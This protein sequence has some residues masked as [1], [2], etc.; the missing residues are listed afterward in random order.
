MNSKANPATILDL[1]AAGVSVPEEDIRLLEAFYLRDPVRE[2]ELIAAGWRLDLDSP[3]GSIGF[4]RTLGGQSTPFVRYDM[5]VRQEGVQWVP[6]HGD[7]EMA[8]APSAALAAQAVMDFWFALSLRDRLT[9]VHWKE[10]V[11]AGR[12]PALLNVAGSVA[13]SPFYIWGNEDCANSTPDFQQAK[14]IRLALF[15]EGAEDVYIADANGV[16]VVDA[17]IAAHE[18][19]ANAGCIVRPKESPGCAG[20]FLLFV[21]GVHEDALEGGSI[22]DLLRQAESA[23]IVRRHSAAERQ[24]R[25]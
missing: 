5:G 9:H 6:S 2:G 11:E 1:Q 3:D 20:G 7:V 13:Q 25:G 4:V 21:G 19:L 14:A 24:D 8:A 10:L 17:D 23:G 18:V 22:A 15:N 12:S 16:E